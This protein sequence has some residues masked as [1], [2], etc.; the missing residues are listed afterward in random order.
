M[1][2]PARISQSERHEI[3]DDAGN[4]V[5]LLLKDGRYVFYEHLKPGS[6]R[7]RVGQTVMR[8]DVVGSLG[9]TGESTGPHL[10][11]H[12]ARGRDTIPVSFVD[13]PGDGIP[14]SLRRYASGHE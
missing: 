10:H 6:I 2:E 7:V 14:R 11:F 1:S 8:G 5:V 12:V 4:Y 9:F 3:A 13:I